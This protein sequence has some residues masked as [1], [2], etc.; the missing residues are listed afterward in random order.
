MLPDYLEK[1]ITHK[2]VLLA[3][4]KDFYVNLE[5][6][7]GK[8]RLTRY[9]IFKEKISQPGQVNLIAEI[10]KASPSKG[11]I[12]D[13]FD[14]L[15]IA[16]AYVKNGAAA[17]SILTEDKY[18]LGKP[19]YVKKVT[20]Q[21]AIPALTKDFIIDRAQ[22]YEA[23]LC[24]ASAVLLIVAI[25]DDQKLKFLMSEANRLDMDC[26]VE[27]HDE[28]ELKRALDCGADIIGVNNR[29]LRTFV[30]DLKVS[31]TLLPQIPSSKIR[32]AESGITTHADVVKLQELGVNAVLIGETFMR[33]T[34]IGAKVREVMGS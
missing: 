21:F 12:R 19:A 26:L 13:D 22:I 16:D 33:A 1:I 24:G 20:D 29:N 28:E 7:M 25:L 18:F 8:A 27:V 6:N 30:V 31:E 15:K 23:F 2:K 10:K 5:T 14:V 17:I 34:D 32:V 3:R 4:K 9:H 11:L